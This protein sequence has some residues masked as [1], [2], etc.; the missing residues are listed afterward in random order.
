MSFQDV[1]RPG[2]RRSSSNNNYATQSLT[3]LSTGGFGVGEN[4]S[5]ENKSA[6]SGSAATISHGILQYQRNVGILDDIARSIGTKNDGAVLE[7]QL[8]AQ[9]DVIRQLG[10]KIEKQLHEQERGM[11]VLP[12]DDAPRGRATHIKLTRDYRRVETTFKNILLEST[13]RRNVANSHMRV[14][15]EEKQRKTFE[16]NLEG[17]STKMQMQ[18]QDDRINE[19]IMRE[20]AE[21]IRNINQGMHQ[22]NEI[23]KDLA[24]IVGDQQG[25]VDQVEH[26][27]ENAALNA[28]KG[29]NQIEKANE[30]GAESSCIIS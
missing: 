24:H 3:G 30:K 18:L 16:K 14:L 17:D 22:V 29:L 7:T 20:R 13:R 23:Y 27:M 4:S 25:Q 10:S 28:E 6:F 8:K 12:R 5:N 21:E 19:E 15:E 11:Q 26:Q 9:V 1:G 2:A